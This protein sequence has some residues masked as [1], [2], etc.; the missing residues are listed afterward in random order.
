M[1]N[2]PICKTL[3]TECSGR[4]EYSCLRCGEFTLS[5]TLQS[6]I[7]GQLDKDAYRRALM[8]HKIRRMTGEGKPLKISSD[9]LDKFWTQQAM[10]KP[11]EQADDL[12]LWLG[13][14][15][16]SY[17][18]AKKSELY[19][20]GA[21]VGTPLVSTDPHSGVK[22]L[23]NHL[24]DK[25][26]LKRSESRDR[27]PNVQFLELTM[28]GWQRHAELKKRRVESRTAFMAMKFG[29]Y[30]LDRVVTEYFKPA[31]ARTGFELRVATDQQPAGLIDN[32]VRA[33]LLGS[34]FV[35]ADLSHANHGAYW[36]AGFAEG[37]GRPVFYTCKK[38]VWED[39]KTHFDTNH[40][41]TIIW[42][43]NDPEKAGDD[44]T[45]TIRATLREEAR[46]EDP[47]IDHSPRSRPSK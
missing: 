43:E 10:P 13:D 46:Q 23:I 7:A 9:T 18:Y 29:N 36:E 19:F 33:L 14:H 42:D 37:L 24:K 4:G 21:W 28:D 22:Y 34:R 2:C 35:V 17:D 30:D 3:G 15:Q 16:R 40:M 11:L 8:S 12:I 45:D 41:H 6:T 20:L 26:L 44:L 31:V 1:S 5:G 38:S 39:E 47:E 25:N 32:H 27:D